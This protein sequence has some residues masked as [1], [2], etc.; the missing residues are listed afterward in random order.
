MLA[1]TMILGILYNGRGNGTCTHTIN[2]TESV[3]FRTTLSFDN[4]H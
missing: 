2:T 4:Q 3:D 1:L